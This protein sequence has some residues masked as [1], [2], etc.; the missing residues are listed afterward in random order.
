VIAFAVAR[1][2]F[3]LYALYTLLFADSGLSAAQVSTLLMIWSA[4]AFVLE[5]PSGVWADLLDRRMLL[6][7]GAVLQAAAFATWM[8]WPAYLGYALGF[9]V[10]SMGSALQSGTFEALVFDEL[11]T[12]GRAASYARLLGLSQ[13]VAMGVMAMAIAAAAPLYALGGY[14]L[15]GWTSVALALLGVPAALAL[16]RAR[17]VVATVSGRPAEDADDPSRGGVLRAYVS[18][19]GAGLGEAGSSRPVRRTLLLLFLVVVVMAVDEF[20]P[21]VASDLGVR[22]AHVPWLIAACSLM[23]AVG[24]AAVGWTAS[25]RRAPFAALVLVAGL[26]LAAGATTS[27]PWG[28]ALV[29]LGYGLANNAMVA[30]EAQLQHR[31]S[32]RARA[33]VTSV[34][35]LVKEGAALVGFATVGLLTSGSTVAPAVAAVALAAAALG[36]LAAWRALADRASAASGPPPWHHR[37][38]SDDTRITVSRT[39]DASA[40]E[41]FDIL[42]NPR[43]HPEVDGSGFIRS[44]DRTNRVQGVGDVFTME[45]SGDHMGGDYRT[46]NHVTGYDKNALLA[47]QTAP[48]GTEPPGWEWVWELKPTGPD[49]TEV[50]LTY[51]WGKVTDPEILKTTGFPLVTQE[52]L[53]ASLGNLAAA[54]SS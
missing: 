54:V 36:A 3:P 35:G 39:I 25:W 24:T 41:L 50:T 12:Q 20:F 14:P 48:E 37:E 43:R 16:P 49:A 42:S 38:M 23:Q 13:G 31:I 28:F 9:V 52:Q 32:G 8:L 34:A 47:W 30:T 44:G 4:T 46:E 7:L 17:A 21:L 10:W 15:V 6:A 53:E 51:D 33:T 27:A 45:M 29:A 11:S 26:L 22:T 2:C 19:L 40:S 5:V 18:T 1:D